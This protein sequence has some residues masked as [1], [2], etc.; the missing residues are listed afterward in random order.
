MNAPGA[1]LRSLTISCSVGIIC[2]CGHAAAQAQEQ[3]EP[4]TLCGPLCAKYVLNY[5][6]R[7]IAMTDI[8]RDTNWSQQ[9]GVSLLD[10]KACLEAHG[11]NSRGVRG[12]RSE[13]EGLL[14]QQTCAVLALPNHFVIVTREQGVLTMIDPSSRAVSKIPADSAPEEWTALIVSDSP[15]GLSLPADKE[16]S[17]PSSRALTG[18][19]GGLIVLG[20]GALYCIGRSHLGRSSRSHTQR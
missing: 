20:I 6:E 17:P 16:S 3:K 1:R 4:A 13:I 5:F 10:L 14:A 8:L 12:N 18:L 9:Y 15:T 11:L 7:D 2:L 19:A